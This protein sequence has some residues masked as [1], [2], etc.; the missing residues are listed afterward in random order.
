MAPSVASYNYVGDFNQ[1]T[2]TETS[3]IRWDAG[4]EF[5]A[6][7]TL[8][9][10][11][12]FNFKNAA[13]NNGAINELDLDAA[14]TGPNASAESRYDWSERG[15]G[16]S[17]YLMKHGGK[18]F[19]Q[20]INSY[21]DLLTSCEGAS[22][23][24]DWVNMGGLAIN[25]EDIAAD[26]TQFVR[27]STTHTGTVSTSWGTNL[28]TL[29]FTPNAIGEK[30]LIIG[31]V[32]YRVGSN[33][34]ISQRLLDDDDTVVQ[35]YDFHQYDTVGT[36]DYTTIPNM[37]IYTAVGTDE[38]TFKVQGM[39]AGTLE[40]FTAH[41][42]AVRILSLSDNFTVTTP[43]DYGIVAAATEEAVTGSDTAIT[44]AGGE[45]VILAIGKNN[46]GT[47]QDGMN[48]WA[49]DDSNVT[50]IP[51]TYTTWDLGDNLM[52]PHRGDGGTSNTPVVY[53]GHEAAVTGLTTYKLY[54]VGEDAAAILEDIEILVMEMDGG[55][56]GVG[57]GGSAGKFASLMDAYY[58][59]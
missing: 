49:T 37:H 23:D 17:G 39:A 27:A 58:G 5:T 13:I 1:T 31:H 51:A 20:S 15:T 25:V 26:A 7:D 40:K 3:R 2:T 29:A 28:E 41:L 14:N 8:L 32:T 56:G 35:D 16:S 6:D 9:M 34:T 11:F 44:G 10:F 24:S 33:E 18:F 36:D 55:D 54:A 53:I 48:M 42:T 45:V 59:R 12:H 19:S 38:V 4:T 21:V 47:A 57:G 50:T 46:P 22:G 52:N 43:S 30:W